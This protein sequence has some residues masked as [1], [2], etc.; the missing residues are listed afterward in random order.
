MPWEQVGD[1]TAPV[2][3][4]LDPDEIPDRDLL[5]ELL[6]AASERALQDLIAF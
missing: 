6:H 5:P 4:S 1:P 3:Q 2:I